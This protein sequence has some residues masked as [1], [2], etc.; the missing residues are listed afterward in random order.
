MQ[1]NQLQQHY[2]ED[3][4]SLTDLCRQL[5]SSKVLAVDTEFVRT[6]T[7]YP[8]LGL[9]QV[10]DGEHL[11]LIDPVAVDD[12]TPFWQLLT[13]GD[14]VKVLHACSED[15]E[16][17]LCAA[18]CKP[19]NLI[20]SQI[21]M[22]FLGQGL[23]MGYAAM[24][25]HYTGIELDKSE[26]RT[27]WTKRPLS[28]RQL[29]YARADVLHLFQVYPQILEQLQSSG[30]LEAAEQETR[31]LI[32]RKFKP[33]D[34]DGLYRNL[35]M[36]WRLNAKQLNNLKFLA[37]WRYQRAKVRD[38]PLGFIAKDDTLI[39][40][41]QRAPKSVGAM[42]HIEG[43]DVLDIRHQGK[44]MLAVLK[45]ADAVGEENYPDKIIR[46]DEYPGY[47]QIFKKV[48]NFIASE[49]KDANLAVE[50]LASKKQI[51]QFLSWYFKINGA[52]QDTASV[53]ILLNWRLQLF[54]EKLTRFA[55]S[56]FGDSN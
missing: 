43:I 54:G 37:R 25:Q 33:V 20:D 9:L 30:W 42:A 2:I 26:S 35:K 28:P 11:A 29:S 1:E 40:L 36:S 52:G 38:L 50:N 4:S 12:L 22:S 16:V 23:S 14:I 41:S 47:K 7:L 46:L 39:A 31:L 53:D 55:Q 48:K 3:F 6:R 32:E 19:V 51:N 45:Q 21:M 49:A 17:F 44:A 27:D 13:N 5:S 15:L 56:G 18:N 8:K 10:C 34:E 24:I